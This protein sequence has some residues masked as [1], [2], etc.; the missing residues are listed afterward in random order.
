[1]NLSED[2]V[3]H[4]RPTIN[5]VRLVTQLGSR[6]ILGVR[7][8]MH[9]SSLRWRRAI[10]FTGGVRSARLFSLPTHW[11]L[12]IHPNQLNIRC[13]FGES[14]LSH[15]DELTIYHLL[16]PPSFPTALPRGQWAIR[17][18][19]EIS[20]STAYHLPECRPCMYVANEMHT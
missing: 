20:R 16:L 4:R 18:Y 15:V 19:L 2:P 13:E 14:F 9:D 17:T 5:P 7:C 10:D 12:V 6:G 11:D 8:H 3:G 1:M